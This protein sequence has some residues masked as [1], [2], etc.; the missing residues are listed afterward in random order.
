M[1]DE[2]LKQV[3]VRTILT[4]GQRTDN[5]QVV[6]QCNIP[7]KKETMEALLTAIFMI[8]MGPDKESKIIKPI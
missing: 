1:A 2:A 4:I 3:P 7:S 5:N 8:A 6:I